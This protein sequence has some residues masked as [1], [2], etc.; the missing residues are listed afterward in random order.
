MDKYEVG[1]IVKYNNELYYVY[2][3]HQNQDSYGIINVVNKT[4]F[5]NIKADLLE[6]VK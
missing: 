3:V 5:F 2:K 1:Q 4:T 6:A